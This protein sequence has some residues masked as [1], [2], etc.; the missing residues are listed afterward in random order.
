[1]NIAL[2]VLL[3]VNLNVQEVSSEFAIYIV[4]NGTI[5]IGKKLGKNN[6]QIIELKAMDQLLD[7]FQYSIN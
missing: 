4:Q 3:S 1:M 7:I 2:L 5:K 6:Y